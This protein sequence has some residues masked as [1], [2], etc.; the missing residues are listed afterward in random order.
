MAYA[1]LEAADNSYAVGF[2]EAVETAFD[3]NC[4]QNL[5]LFH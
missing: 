1:E 5:T 4:T 2:S 3:K